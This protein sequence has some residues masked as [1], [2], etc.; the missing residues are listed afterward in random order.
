MGKPTR[1]G[2]SKDEG[3][4]GTETSQYL[5]EKKETSIPSVAASEPGSAQTE[6]LAW[7]GWRTSF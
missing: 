1:K 5:K 7:R 2:T 3:T 4:Q 6:T